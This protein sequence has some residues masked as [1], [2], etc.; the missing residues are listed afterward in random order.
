MNKFNIGN[1]IQK[2]G[3]NDICTIKDIDYKK[4]RYIICSEETE[5]DAN[6]VT[7]YI[8]FSDESKYKLK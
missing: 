8:N 3:T 6:N 7:W 4:S 2:I 5:L 1:K